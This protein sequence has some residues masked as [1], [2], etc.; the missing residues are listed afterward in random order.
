MDKDEFLNWFQE[1]YEKD[2]NGFI[3]IKDLYKIYKNSS[4]FYSLSKAQQRQN[5]EKYFRQMVIKKMYMH[6]VPPMGSIEI[7]TKDGTEKIQTT[8]D[9][10]IGF[11]QGF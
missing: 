7:K 1:E 2:E 5:N 3:S 11:T 10:I 9:G 6:Y 4:L 8:K